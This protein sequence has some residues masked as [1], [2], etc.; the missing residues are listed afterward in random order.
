MATIFLTSDVL[1]AAALVVMAWP[2]AGLASVAIWAAP[3]ALC[4]I[5]PHEVAVA[6][7]AAA[8][9]RT[10]NAGAKKQ[11]CAV[12]EL[13]LDWCCVDGNGLLSRLAERLIGNG[14]VMLA[15]YMSHVTNAQIA[16]QWAGG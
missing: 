14:E 8:E 7:S 13:S 2:G 6:A 10:R 4:G 3:I 15:L 11:W 5:L 16:G 9:T 12:I 1:F